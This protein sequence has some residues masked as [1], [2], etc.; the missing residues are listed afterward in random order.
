MILR[1][2]YQRCY[3]V[4]VRSSHTLSSVC[5]NSYGDRQPCVI[6]AHTIPAGT[7]FCWY[8]TTAPLWPEVQQKLRTRHSNSLP[9]GD[10][11]VST[12]IT[13][14]G[15][16]EPPDTVDQEQVLDEGEFTDNSHL[17]DRGSTRTRSLIKKVNVSEDVIEDL[18]K[19]LDISCDE[20]LHI[21]HP[22]DILEVS[23]E[24]LRETV[25][26]LKD[27][28][29][30]SQQLKRVP[31]ILLESTD[32]LHKK[33]QKLTEPY[34][35]QNWSDG[36]GFCH[37]TV[38]RMEAYRKIFMSEANNFPDHPNRIYYL[39]EKLKVPVE[40]LTE[41]IIKP[42]KILKIKISRLNQL[43]DI[44]HEYGVP[45]ED[46]L[47]DLWVFFYNTEKIEV[48]LQRVAQLGIHAPKPWM[49][50]CSLEIFE[51]FCER[52][53]T[54]K[55]LMGD[56]KDLLGYLSE[57]LEC[58]PK[59]ITKHLRSNTVLRKIHISKLQ[60]ILD[61]FYSEGLSSE[62]VRSCIR[63]LQ[64]SEER[65]AQRIKELKEVG[66]FPFPII[67][68]C[69]TP[70]NFKKIVDRFKEQQAILNSQVNN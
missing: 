3:S 32:S 11:T 50:R 39:A 67:L 47:S 70:A 33:F 35:F 61:L 51:R 6:A 58:E 15:S 1:N 65:T 38:E 44:F 2:F 25:H 62:D 42:H 43:L 22:S 29:I 5:C 30:T 64:Y 24:A 16:R 8:Q 52:F 17:E 45:P 19:L 26:F 66:F 41:K 27:H 13:S 7:S 56:H 46:L 55:R 4:S 10:M 69:K 9:S 49:C 48:R 63:V 68:L 31:W 18:T 23:D 59:M 53:T 21:V 57:R 60:R 54:E 40:Q 36:L 20:A 37:F 12:K 28:N 14:P 34:M